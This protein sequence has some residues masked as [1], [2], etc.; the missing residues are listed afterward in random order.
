MSNKDKTILVVDDTIANLDLLISYLGN[1][2]YKTLIAKDGETALRRAAEKLPDLI[3]LDI[4]MPGIDG[5][6]T[7]QKL[8][9]N[10]A[11]KDI[12]VIFMTALTDTEDKVKGFNK[13]AVDYITKPIDVAELSAR[14]TTHLELYDMKVELQKQNEILKENADLRESMEQIARHD[15]KTPLSA[16]IMLPQM[17]INSPRI[18]DKEKRQITSIHQA[19]LKM[20][21]LI[22]RSMDMYKMERNTYLPDFKEVNVLHTIKDALDNLQPAYNWDISNMRFLINGRTCTKYDECNIL[23]ED[24]LLYSLFSNLIKNALEASPP[25]ELIEIDVQQNE[26]VIVSIKNKG[27]VPENIRDI[28]FEKFVTSKNGKG[29]GLGTYSAKLIAETLHGSISL[30]TSIKDYTRLI[31]GLKKA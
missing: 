21:Q 23:G 30:D 10:E 17:L 26:S 7:C 9:E 1:N 19:G 8:K 6:E 14:V 31:V 11:T 4:Q 13:G 2:G 24:L 5:F 12:P 25:D 3:L 22:N 15:L 28:F 18:N 16:I 27:E 29:T 20:L